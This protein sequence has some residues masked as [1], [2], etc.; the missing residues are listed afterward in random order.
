MSY[1]LSSRVEEDVRI[2]VESNPAAQIL[3]SAANTTFTSINY[4]TV[5]YKPLRYID[6]SFADKVI[7]SSSFLVNANSSTN[8]SGATFRLVYSTDNGSTWS[9]WGD[10]TKFNFGSW[11]QAQLRGT[12]LDINFCLDT[13]N[14][15]EERLLKLEGECWGPAG[16]QVQLHHN[17]HFYDNNGLVTGT[18]RYLPKVSCRSIKQ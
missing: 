17:V 8:D 3:S 16:F 14:W 5:R 4:T 1:L 11:E 18:S 9:A 2:E 12:T 15:S 13:T 7:Y 6:G 10:N